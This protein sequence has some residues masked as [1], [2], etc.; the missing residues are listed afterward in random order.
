MFPARSPED[1]KIETVRGSLG[2]SP[3]AGIAG[4][5]VPCCDALA[6]SGIGASAIGV[7]S[8]ACT[9]CAVGPGAAVWIN[10]AE[11]SSSSSS[12]SIMGAPAQIREDKKYG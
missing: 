6:Y 2:N 9:A 8:E 5:K 4:S 11:A 3:K 1:P 10:M 12:S 7:A